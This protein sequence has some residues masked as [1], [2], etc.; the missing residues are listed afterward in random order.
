MIECKCKECGKLFNTYNKNAKYCSH[1]CAYKNFKG[2]GN[3]NSKPKIE[4]I[5]I[6][7]NKHFFVQPYQQ[8]K[9]FCGNKCHSEWISNN[10]GVNSYRFNSISRICKQCGKEFFIS[11]SRLKD[12]QGKF[13]SKECY[14]NN[15]SKKLVVCR[16][17]GVE[18]FV[19]QY[20]ADK[21]K[22]CSH[23]C[24]EIYQCGINNNFYG[25]HHSIITRNKIG[26]LAKQRFQ[27]PEFR[28]KVSGENSS[29]WK[30]GIST[31]K[32]LIRECAQMYEW[33]KKVFDRDNYIDW[34]TG[35]KGGVLNVHHIKPISKIIKENNIK[36]MDD[37]FNCHDLWDMNNGI[38]M[39]EI[40]HK[41]HHDL[42]GRN[43]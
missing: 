14:L 34:Y 16:Q 2:S 40:S 26:S 21:R 33:K 20:L 37:A 24:S 41:W 39:S 12:R 11:P 15:N 28:K 7:C 22:F 25:K 10:K 38:T 8:D 31:I 23:K 42:W 13:C 27:D 43:R 6:Q 36:T 19:R 30:G 32:K 3:P 5:C 18:F 4:K 9:I 35:I 29:Q 1:K 17:C